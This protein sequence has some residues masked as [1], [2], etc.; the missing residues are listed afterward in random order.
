MDK[1]LHKRNCLSDKERYADLINGLL[2]EGEQKVH[3]DD[4]SDLDSQV[5]G[6]SAW[7]SNRKKNYRRLS[8]DII[9]KTA[10]GVNFIVIGVENQKETREQ[11]LK[12]KGE[13]QN[14]EERNDRLHRGFW[15]GD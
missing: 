14:D 5:S 13:I 8:R 9:T 7:F 6:W 10:V 2:L 1:D 3:P 12:R 4:L 11:N 15:Y